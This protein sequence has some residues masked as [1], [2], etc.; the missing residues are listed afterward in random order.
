MGRKI[1]R[2]KKEEFLHDVNGGKIY[3]WN[4]NWG[5]L[6]FFHMPH[7]IRSM[8]QRQIKFS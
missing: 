7:I 1:D 4:T 2:E 6:I 3:E 5:D 8:W